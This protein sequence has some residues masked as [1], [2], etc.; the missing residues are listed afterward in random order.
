MNIRKKIA[1]VV[2]SALAFAGFSSVSAQAAPTV[3]YTTMYDTTNGIQVVNGLA[4]LTISTDTSTVTSVVLSGVGSILAANAGT[5]TTISLAPSPTVSG[6]VNSWYQVTTSSVGAGTSTVTLYSQNVGTSTIT[7]T[8]VNQATG[9]PGTPVVKTVTWTPTGSLAVNAGYTTVYMAA[10][11]TTPTPT[12]NAVAITAAK[13]LGTTA[14]QQVANIVVTPHDSNNNLLAADQ[15]TAVVSGTGLIGIGTATGSINMQGR[16]LTG[17]A[18]SYVINVF[19]DGTAG[20]STITISDGTTVLA[21]KTLIFSGVATKYVVSNERSAY[22]V[23]ANGADATATALGSGI[24]I[25]VTDAA[26]NPVADGTIVYA[27]STNPTIAT[28]SASTTTIGGVAYFGVTGVSTGTASFTFTDNSTTSLVTTLATDSIYVGSSVASK[29]SLAFDNTSYAN[30]SVVK[31]KLTA[32]DA[33]GK[34]ISDVAAAGYSYTNFLSTD[35]ISSTQ[36]GGVSLV[37]SASP[38]FVGGVA[39]WDLYAPLS[40]GPFTVTATTGVATGLSLVAQKVAL[41][42]SATIAVDQSSSLAL[43]A[44][45]AATDAA[46]NAYDEAQNATQAASD[47]LAAVKSLSLQVSVLIATVKSLAAMV[48]KIAKKQG[49]K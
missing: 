44:A 38:T 24:A 47:A 16:A 26:G 29:V 36:L 13:T 4:T 27:T 12:T 18:G 11:A 43:D 33:N 2:V 20:T 6:G 23:G 41:S 46:N 7:V 32:L 31:L 9:I 19:G 35:L 5:N 48:A 22:R 37:G 25:T 8:P 42:A 10:G 30:G 40:A 17:T 1:V 39:T 21:T 14:G 15:I 28:L 3:A 49:V 45:N 34:P